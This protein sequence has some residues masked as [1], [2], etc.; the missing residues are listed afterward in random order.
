M[1][2]RIDIVVTQHE[3]LVALLIER[4]IITPETPVLTHA[5]AE[6]VKGKHVLGVLPHHLSSQAATITEIPIRFTGAEQ[7]KAFAGGDIPLEQLTRMAGRPVTYK[8]TDRWHPLESAPVT[9]APVPGAD[10]RK[11]E[12]GTRIAS[13]SSAILALLKWQAE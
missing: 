9:Y 13:C 6:D 11:D 2:P 7:R 4:G 10:G 12:R 5:T 3:T 1:T 8:V